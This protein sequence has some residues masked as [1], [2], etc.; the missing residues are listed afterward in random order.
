MDASR[1]A[2]LGGLAAAPL[3]TR[4]VFASDVD[5]WAAF[6]AL[7]LANPRLILAF[8]HARRAGAKPNQILAIIFPL[9][10]F[11]DA[12]DWPQVTFLPG[13]PVRLATPKEVW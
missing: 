5:P 12:E 8:D 9:P 7:G 10:A 1:R 2:I 11:E 6:A 3:T 13:S 4:T